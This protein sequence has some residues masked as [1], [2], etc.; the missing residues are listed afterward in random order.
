MK[1]HIYPELDNNYVKIVKK[2]LKAISKK[3]KKKKIVT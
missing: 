2:K 1:R 3:D